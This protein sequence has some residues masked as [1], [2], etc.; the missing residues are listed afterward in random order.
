MERITTTW[1][2]TIKMH[3]HSFSKHYE[4]SEELLEAIKVFIENGVTFNVSNIEEMPA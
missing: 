3:G 2:I 1:I 4:N